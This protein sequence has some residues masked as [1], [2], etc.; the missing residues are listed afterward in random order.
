[1]R[2]GASDTKTSDGG[3]RIDYAAP[4]ADGHTTRD[5]EDK[6]DA[7]CNS[8]GIEGGATEFLGRSPEKEAF[9]CNFRHYVEDD[10]GNDADFD[11]G[12]EKDDFDYGDEKDDFGCGDEK[13]S[14]DDRP[15]HA[16]TLP[17]TINESEDED[18]TMS[19]EV[20]SD[21]EES[22]KETKRRKEWDREQLE[23]LTERA[24]VSREF[25]K[26]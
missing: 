3:G 5:L 20:E 22:G 18:E 7:L 2:D 19:G 15:R 21:E 23:C 4:Q 11:Y 10:Y 1:M 9:A 26:L 25:L 8:P 13:D 24:K 16:R 6:P 14:F 17:R 12:D